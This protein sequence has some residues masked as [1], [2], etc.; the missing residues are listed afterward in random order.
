MTIEVS[1]YNG[2]LVLRQRHQSAIWDYLAVFLL[3]T[4]LVAATLPRIISVSFLHVGWSGVGLFIVLSL[5]A[6]IC[7]YHRAE[8]TAL[9][10]KDE[11]R[12]L[13]PRYRFGKMTTVDMISFDDILTVYTDKLDPGDGP[14]TFNLRLQLC[15][16]QD[17][18][19]GKSHD[20]ECIAHAADL[21]RAAIHVR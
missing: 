1:W 3:G 9:V 8:V 12:V 14:P 11:A 2:A 15:A 4:L 20:G 16:G 17:R 6:A 13:L 18:D 19:L 5:V 10:V 21:V 7:R